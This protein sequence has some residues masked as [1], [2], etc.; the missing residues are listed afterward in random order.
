MKV[1]NAD[2][3]KLENDGPKLTNESH[4]LYIYMMF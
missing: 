1:L 3:P 2:S 4:K